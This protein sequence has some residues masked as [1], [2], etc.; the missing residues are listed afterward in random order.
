VR[1]LSSALAVVALAATVANADPAVADPRVG[2]FSDGAAVWIDDELN[3][4]GRSPNDSH[5]NI[6][7]RSPLV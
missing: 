1:A 5:G 3:G 2:G 4:G 6:R 7:L